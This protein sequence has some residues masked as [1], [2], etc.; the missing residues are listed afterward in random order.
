MA[1]S[2]FTDLE[3]LEPRLLL[4]ATAA[5]DVPDHAPAD[6][7]AVEVADA[8][9]IEQAASIASLSDSESQ[10]QDIFGDL[11]STS[12]T[13]E[14]SASGEDSNVG[15]NPI[16]TIDSAEL[17]AVATRAVS[18]AEDGAEDDAD[19]SAKNNQNSEI[20]TA[21]EAAV[22][23]GPGAVTTTITAAAG[24]G[25][26]SP[27]L[28]SVT[29][30]LEETLRAANGPPGSENG[31]GS[32]STSWVLKAGE[33][34][35][36]TGSP[37]LDLFNEAGVLS[38]GHSP[39]VFNVANY[40]QSPAASQLIEITGWNVNNAPVV[41][42]Q[43]IA[44]GN[45]TLDGTLKIKLT[46]FTPLVGQTFSILKWG[47]VRVGEFANYLGTTVPGN[48][49]LALVP[50]YDDGAKELRLR[51]IDTESVALEVERGLRDIATMAGN[52]LNFSLPGG[53]SLPL[54]GKPLKDLLDAKKMV[55][56]T[57]QG[58]LLSVVN[59]L[60]PQAQVTQEIEKLEGQV[61]GNFTVKV[62]SVLG[63]YSNP[64][65][66][67]KFY[68]WDVKLTLVETKL[69][70]LLSSGLNSLFDFAFGSGSKLTL[71][72]TLELDF[73][74]GYDD[75]D[76][77]PLTPAAFVDLRSITPRAKA[78]ASNLNPLKFTPAWLLAN[79][80]TNVSATG[81]IA[82]ETFIKFAPDPNTFPSGHWLAT[83]PPTLPSLSNF[84]HTEA[85]S[86]DA[87][88]VLNASLS[89][90]NNLW[91]PFTFAKYSGQHTL[92]IVD[93]NL[94]DN[95]KSDVTL[96]IDGDLLVFGQ[97]L[98]GIFTLS[99][100][101][102]STD[103]AIDANVTNL[104]LKL[105]VGIGPELRILKATGTGNFL[106]K[107]NGDLAGVASLTI[108]PGGGPQIPNIDDLSGAFTLTFNGANTPSTVPVPNNPSVV[109]PGGG[110]YYRIDGQNITLDLGL[111]DIVLHATKFTF[112]PIDTYAGQ[113]KRQPAGRRHRRPGVVL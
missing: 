52:L 66:P 14:T 9:G 44:A 48:M 42:D 73:T 1:W 6:S 51:V 112:E 29:E 45:V 22:Q 104:E 113:S 50:E 16:L 106:L 74:F 30:Q 107:D 97:K 90:P 35:G 19:E 80:L 13:I 76:G 43:F 17:T 89:D 60:T 11:S 53:T 101:G 87:T 57:I 108:A 95:V 24:P 93:T 71:E 92:H 70:D 59:A 63:H 72:D 27:D 75:T 36:G 55:E 56:D 54:I 79:P 77:N 18:T 94:F 33:I 96:I 58:K 110:P 23:P 4:S 38:P 98:T 3:A 49:Q 5:L 20:T 103:I 46:G 100:S 41:Y 25:G 26:S 62:T 67:A 86:V 65:N 7:D 40:T 69:T 37:K 91:A 78:V 34:L 28:I 99:K 12:Q 32:G 21:A 47:G 10:L 31:S 64:S 2:A 82:F 61:F 81:N 109:I 15:A 68:S 105:T 102:A 39:G 85:A 8:S 83:E 111:P 88:I 84:S